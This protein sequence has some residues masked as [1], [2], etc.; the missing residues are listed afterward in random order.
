MDVTPTPPRSA[1]GAFPTRTPLPTTPALPDPTII[2]NQVIKSTTLAI[3]LLTSVVM[4][5]LTEPFIRFMRMRGQDLK[6]DQESEAAALEEAAV[7]AALAESA[8]QY[9]AEHGRGEGGGE[10]ATVGDAD[11]LNAQHSQQYEEMAGSQSTA[12]SALNAVNKTFELWKEFDEKYMRQWFGGRRAHDE[13]L[14]TSSHAEKSLNVHDRNSRRQFHASSA[15]T[16]SSIS[17]EPVRVPSSPIMS[18]KDPH[19]LFANSSG[20]GGAHHQ[21][22]LGSSSGDHI[23]SILSPLIPP[24]SR[25]SSSSSSSGGISQRVGPPRL[26]GLG[27]PQLSAP[28]GVRSNRNSFSV[29]GAPD[30][31]AE[32]S[33]Y[34]ILAESA[35]RIKV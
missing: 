8:A 33:H 1:N 24:S 34:S 18:S 26:G 28:V 30:L 21:L 11:P 14:S 25:A 19:D 15:D 22:H 35:Q 17:L 27:M 13:L 12:Y 16:D 4:G 9:E 5:A 3:V 29:A 6:A 31:F 32:D 20:D 2:T 7:A 10:E 23:S